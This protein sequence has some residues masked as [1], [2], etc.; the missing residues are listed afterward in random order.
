MLTIIPN[1]T[2]VMINQHDE[3]VGL[4]G[5]RVEAIWPIAARG[6]IR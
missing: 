6:K 4:R 1:G 2:E 3:F 5:G